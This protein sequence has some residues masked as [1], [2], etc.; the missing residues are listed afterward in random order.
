MKIQVLGMGCPKCK[1]TMEVMHEAAMKLGLLEGSDY[2]LE[3]VD[4]INEIMTFGV[5]ITPGVAID[6]KVMVSGKVPSVGEAATFITNNLS[7]EAI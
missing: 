1:K 6:G 3:K 2:V 4:T 5:T 7:E